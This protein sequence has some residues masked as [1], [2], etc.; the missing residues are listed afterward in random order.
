MPKYRTNVGDNMTGRHNIG[1]NLEKEMRKEKGFSLIEVI[2]AIGILSV[3]ILGVAT[4]QVTSIRGNAFADKVTQATT[5]GGD[6]IEKLAC[7]QWDSAFLQDSDGD[8]VNGLNDTG[9]D[10]DT[11]T[12]GDSDQPLIQQGQYTIQWNVAED[13]LIGETKTVHV[14]VT[15]S[16]HGITKNVIIRRVIP[17][18]I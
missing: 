2:I 8:G 11:D 17:R 13:D 5:W 18:T 6:R 7:L 15:W 14:I 4:M 3:G 10:N 16:D 12:Q 1:N 9:F